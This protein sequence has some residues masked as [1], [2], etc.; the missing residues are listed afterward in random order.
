MVAIFTMSFSSYA[1][2]GTGRF[3]EGLE[4]SVKAMELDQDLLRAYGNRAEIL[5]RMDR[6][7]DAESAFSQAAAHGISIGFERGSWYQ[8]G[9]LKSSPSVMEAALTDSHAN[10]ETDIIM[11]HIQALAA[12]HD[13]RIEEANRLSRRVVDL[14]KAS[15]WAERAA[16]VQA[17]PG[18]WSAFYGN[19]EAARSSAKSALKIF[20][21]RDSTYAAGFALGL[22][23]NGALAA[24]LADK[25]NKAFKLPSVDHA[26]WLLPGRII[27]S[28]ESAG[29][30][31]SGLP[32]FVP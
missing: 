9:F 5:M 6:L 19:R 18:V 31:L 3:K 23:G 10:A 2:N 14:A 21:G 13:G 26:P 11:T 4:A 12:A 28:L 25:L 22:S 8:L 24:T 20:E 15:G 7:D 29:K 27:G 17:A 16:V 1:A 32:T 30:S